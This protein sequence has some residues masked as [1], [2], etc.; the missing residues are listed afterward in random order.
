M[1]GRSGSKCLAC[2]PRVCRPSYL[3]VIADDS[4]NLVKIGCT[5]N[6]ARR[7]ADYRGN[8]DQHYR[9]IHQQEAGCEFTATRKEERA[10]GALPPDKRVRGDWFEVSGDD[11][12][13]AVVAALS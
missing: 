1:K 3:Y 13:K 11:A 2:S 5:V 6:V 9:I 10:L 7:L 8:G 12:V 4:R